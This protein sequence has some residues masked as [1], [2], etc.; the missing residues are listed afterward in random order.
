MEYESDTVFLTDT[1]FVEYVREGTI[2]F[3]YAK[4][5][6]SDEIQGALNYLVEQQIELKYLNQLAYEVNPESIISDSA[7]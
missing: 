2:A 1:G 3:V 6:D 4:L 5:D 7:Y